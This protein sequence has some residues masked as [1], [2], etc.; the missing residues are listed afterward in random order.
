MGR[1]DHQLI[2]PAFLTSINLCKRKVVVKWVLE[3]YKACPPEKNNHKKFH[4]Q[5][6]HV[7]KLG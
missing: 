2:L 3:V 4:F 7:Y 6:P 1:D 5:D